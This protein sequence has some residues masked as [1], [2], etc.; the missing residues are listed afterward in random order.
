MIQTIRE[1]KY[2][3][4]FEPFD[5]EL[6]NGRVLHV[7]LPDSVAFSEEQNRVAVFG[8]DGTALIVPVLQIT[9]VGHLATPRKKEKEK[10]K[11]K[12]K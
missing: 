9:D 6:S 7:L 2:A 10:R 12:R 1:L 3:Q 11:H 5:I 4:P 8:A